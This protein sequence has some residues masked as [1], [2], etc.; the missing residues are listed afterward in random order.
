MKLAELFLN[1]FLYK[2]TSQ[3][4]ETKGADFISADSTDTEPA[5]I[6]SGGA[7]QDINTGNVQING[8][9]LEPGTYP[10]TVLDVSNWGWGQT[11]AFT[12]GVSSDTVTW[13]AGTFT[14]ASG[15][16]YSIDAGTTGVMAAKTYI[17]LSLLESE[18]EYQISTTSSDSVGLG[19]VLI[20]VAENSTAPDLATYMLSEATQI[21]GDNILANTIDASKIVTGQLVVGTNVGIGTAEDS[22]GVTTIIG[23]VVDTGF[24]NA[25]EITVLGTV[26]AG[27]INGGTMNINDNSIIDS[28][29]EATFV[30]V[31]TLNMKAYTN[32]EGSGRF[33]TSVGGSGAATFGNQGCTIAPGA[34]A[35]SFCRMLWWITNSVFSSKPTFTCSLLCLGGFTSSD[36]VA[37]VGLGT[38]TFSGLGFTETTGHIAGFEFKKSGGATTMTILQGDNSGN[39]DYV[40]D[41]TTLTNN[42]SL[43]LYIKVNTSDIQYYYR[44]NGSTLTLGATLSDYMPTAGNYIGF[45]SSNKGNAVDFQV[46]LQ[47]A[48]YEH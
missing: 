48:A 25:L 17:Y 37:F 36:G 24:I 3:D 16:T 33:I 7:A 45:A 9:Q 19:K 11:C 8:A 26:T 2:D 13:G 14:S 32:F 38:P 12:S 35:T 39:V 15:D 20:A 23:N 4:S 21:V 6:P 42:D 27:A 30:G 5:S 41:V 44:K 40:N 18:T 22:A 10:L 28:D 34:T 29:G 31:T 1:R 46:Q 43:E 47:C